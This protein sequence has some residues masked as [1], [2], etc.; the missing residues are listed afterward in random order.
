MWSLSGG[1]GPNTDIE[2]RRRLTRSWRKFAS[3]RPLAADVR[4]LQRIS[5]LL[6]QSRHP[7]RVGAC[8]LLG[9]KRIWQFRSV[10]SACQPDSDIERWSFCCDAE[11]R[12]PFNN[13]VRSGPRPEGS[14]GGGANSSL[15]SAARQIYVAAGGDTQQPERMRRI[16]VLMPFAEN[17]PQRN[18]PRL[19]VPA[20]TCAAGLDRRPQRADGPALGRGR[21]W[22][23]TRLSRK[24]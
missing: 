21:I 4:L 1:S 5:P 19:R 12:F 9:V 11:A 20:G 17:D 13:V 15:L 18:G 7:D 22:T 10:T 6:A 8:P 3:A 23:R 24:N 14:A 2:F 16:G